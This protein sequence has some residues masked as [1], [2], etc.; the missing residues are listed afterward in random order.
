MN[1]VSIYTGGIDNCLCLKT[2]LCGADKV[3]VFC[4]FD[5]C[6]FCS[7]MELCTVHRRILRQRNSKAKGTDDR[8]CRRIQRCHGTLSHLRLQLP[9]LFLIQNGDLTHPVLFSTLFQLL[10]LIHI[11]F[12][13]A[14]NKRSVFLI[15]KIQLLGELFHH[16][17]SFKVKP[18]HQCSRLSIKAGMGDTT[19][20]LGSTF[21]YICTLFQHCD[22]QPFS[23]KLSCNGA[24]ADART[25]NYYIKHKETPFPIHFI[26]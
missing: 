1:P 24:A 22:L 19:V 6:Y 20:R 7:E 16:F 18:C 12:I 8:T 15:R 3:T 2:A 5:S 21:A 11:F 4:L 13:K 26:F 17:A 23:G 10:Q 14:K 25:D 9:E